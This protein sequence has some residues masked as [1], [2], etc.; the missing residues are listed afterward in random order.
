MVSVKTENYYL[1][2]LLKFFK[3]IDLLS[4]HGRGKGGGE[5]VSK[6]ILNYYSS[7]KN[8]S[9]ISIVSSK[10]SFIKRFL[11]IKKLRKSDIILFTAGIRDVDVILFSIFLGKKF[12]VYNQV[13]YQKAINFK[14][15]A[16]H[17]L[18][19]KLYIFLLENFCTFVLSNSASALKL[20]RKIEILLPILSNEIVF[21]KI[22]LKKINKK[23]IVFGTAFR[24]NKERGIGSKDIDGLISFCKRISKLMEEKSINFSVIHYGEFDEE[25][26]SRIKNN[27]SNIEFVGYTLNWFEKDIDAYFFISKYEGFGLAP[28][29]ASNYKPVFVNDVFPK[30]I[31]LCS[32]NIYLINEIFK[33]I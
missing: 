29:E 17:F 32:P 7:V 10:Y 4:L 16:I 14:I 22:P 20:N 8:N 30:E 6:K 5:V 24:L 12:N 19:V 15:D 23:N 11:C 2:D 3:T 25:I 9:E 26:A 1:D 31:F 33:I 18:L 27:F 13:P 28:L 21:K